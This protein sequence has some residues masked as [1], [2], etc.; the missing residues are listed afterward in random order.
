[1]LTGLL[2]GCADSTSEVYNCACWAAEY[3]MRPVGLQLSEVFEQLL[4]ACLKLALMSVPCTV[5]CEV[6]RLV[7][8]A[9]HAVPNARR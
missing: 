8:C 9:E 5:H 2:T 7:L 1:M 3:H 6:K 4:A